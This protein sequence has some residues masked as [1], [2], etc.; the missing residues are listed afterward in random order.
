MEISLKLQ[1]QASVF[2]AFTGGGYA[3]QEITIYIDDSLPYTT[4]REIVIH[5]IIESLL[6]IAEHEKLDIISTTINDAI[7]KLDELKGV[8]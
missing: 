2:S 3:T 5:E 1:K 8:N 6:F 7:E 4:Q